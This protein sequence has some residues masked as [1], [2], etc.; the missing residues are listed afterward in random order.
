[1][2][3]YKLGYTTC[4]VIIAF[5]RFYIG[6]LVYDH[7]Y[8]IPA[9]ILLYHSYSTPLV[10]YSYLIIPVSYTHLTLPTIYSV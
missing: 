5:I 8:I 9:Y 6:F 3:L 7:Y 1:M 2:L 4:L 10:S